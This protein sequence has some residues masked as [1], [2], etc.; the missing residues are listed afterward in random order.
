[1]KRAALVCGLLM[2]LLMAPTAG[3]QYYYVC[4]THSN[5][6]VVYWANCQCYTCGYTG[7]G[8]TACAN[9]STGSTCYTDGTY[10]DAALHQSP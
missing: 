1:M 3:S 4:E 6:R 9:E 10:C 2:V 8:C 5:S 7:S